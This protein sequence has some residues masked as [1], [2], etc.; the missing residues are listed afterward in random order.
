MQAWHPPSTDTQEYAVNVRLA[1][2]RS[3]TFIA[4]AT[5]AC[6]GLLHLANSK[7]H[8]Q[9]PASDAGGAPISAIHDKIELAQ[10]RLS[11]RLQEVQVAKTE[12]RLLG[13]G[14]DG[15]AETLKA[16]EQELL[17][18]EKHLSH[19]KRL[20]EEGLVSSTQIQGA[21]VM[22]HAK[23]AEISAYK[24]TSADWADKI[25]VHDEKIKLLELR[26]E[27]AK[28]KLDQLKRH[29]RK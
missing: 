13:P 3:V 28:V 2:S 18:L 25:A 17:A 1:S 16:K 10:I 20:Y 11:I 9:E 5:L 24:T 14:A 22:R 21:E 7:V 27:L 12:R 26:A 6:T 23:A 29:L 8:A 4:L 15:A 19:V